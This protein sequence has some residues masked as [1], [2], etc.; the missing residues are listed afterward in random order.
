MVRRVAFCWPTSTLSSRLCLA[1]E[2]LG[3]P[4]WN[5]K[6]FQRYFSKSETAHALSEET[7]KKYGA[8]VVAPAG[9]D[10]PIARSYP[11]WFSDLHLPLFD[12]YKE[13]GVDVNV[14]PVSVFSVIPLFLF[15]EVK[16]NC[17]EIS[18]LTQIPFSSVPLCRMGG[19]TLE[20]PQPRV[21]SPRGNRPV[22]TRLR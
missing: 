7:A 8:E 11:G 5:F 20:L 15:H 19:T 17:L 12:A 4:G 18:L 22:L 21:R 10:G 13:L 1:F 14:D 16:V 2:A 9:V 3:N 6:E